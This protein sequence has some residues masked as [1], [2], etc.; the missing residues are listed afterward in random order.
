MALIKNSVVIMSH[1]SSNGQREDKDNEQILPK[2]KSGDPR[3]QFP[4]NDR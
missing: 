1:T 3:I 2:E 4:V